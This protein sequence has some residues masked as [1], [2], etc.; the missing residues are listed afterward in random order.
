MEWKKLPE[1]IMPNPE[2]TAVQMTEMLGS[3]NNLATKIDHLADT[4]QA[5]HTENSRRADKVEDK[6]E[7]QDE[8]LRQIENQMPLIKEMREHSRD[9]KRAVYG[10]IGSIVVMGLVGGIVFI[11]AGVGG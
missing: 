4:M 8:R 3:L 5:T 7:K 6:L 10:A 11:K 1:I 2:V 9:A